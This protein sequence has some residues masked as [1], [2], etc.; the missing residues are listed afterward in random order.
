MVHPNVAENPKDTGSA[1]GAQSPNAIAKRQPY[2]SETEPQAC[3]DTKRPIIKAVDIRPVYSSILEN[4]IME[5]I[6]QR[7]YSGEVI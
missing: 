5:S 2:R 3:E 6:Q 1:A 4:N 7:D